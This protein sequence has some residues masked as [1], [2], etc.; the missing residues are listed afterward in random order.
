M[1]LPE[2]F[3][4]SFRIA[5]KQSGLATMKEPE[6]GRTPGPCWGPK[7]PL[8]MANLTTRRSEVLQIADKYGREDRR[9]EIVPE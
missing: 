3:S 4:G 7:A 2:K 8:S 1:F 5:L 6:P 9:L